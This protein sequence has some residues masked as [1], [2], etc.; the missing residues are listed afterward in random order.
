M[1]KRLDSLLMSVDHCEDRFVLSVGI[2][3]W[4]RRFLLPEPKPQ[5]F[6]HSFFCTQE[7]N[8]VQMGIWVV[9][10][11]VHQ[12]VAWPGHHQV[13]P[14]L[15]H[16]SHMA[17]LQAE[18]IS[19]SFCVSALSVFLSFYLSVCL[20]LIPFLYL[21]NSLFCTFIRGVRMA[22]PVLWMERMT[23]I[24]HTWVE[25]NTNTENFC[26][27]TW[28]T[29]TWCCTT[30]KPWAWSWRHTVRMNTKRVLLVR[31]NQVAIVDF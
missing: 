30:E 13:W 28:L 31:G 25:E 6:V 29:W 23:Q 11:L 26:W 20:S 7:N 19:L 27:T 1:V 4:Q 3:A 24:I 17:W 10:F 12:K 2:V 15:T 21:K 9:L 18:T 14:E 8:L 5:L 22:Q 16:K